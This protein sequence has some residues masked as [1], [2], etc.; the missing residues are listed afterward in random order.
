MQAA[1]T[2]KEAVTQSVGDGQG[3]RQQRGRIRHGGDQGR[4]AGLRPSPW[5]SGRR[6]RRVSAGR[7]RTRRPCRRPPARCPTS[8]RSCPRAAGPAR[9][10]GRHPP[11]AGRAR[12]GIVVVDLDPEPAAKHVHLEAR[13]AASMRHRVGDQLADEHLDVADELTICVREEIS[14][15]LARGARRLW[16]GR[17]V[18][19]VAAT[20]LRQGGGDEDLVDEA[21]RARRPS[22][23]SRPHRGSAPR[24]ADGVGAGSTAPRSPRPAQRS[25][26][27]GRASSPERPGIAR[28]SRIRCGGLR[29]S[30]AQ[31]LL[32]VVGLA[33]R[34][35][36]PRRGEQP[37]DEHALVRIVVDEEDRAAAPGRSRRH[38]AA[39]RVNRNVEPCPGD[40]CDADA[41]RPAPRR[42]TWR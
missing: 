6:R 27:S 30:A 28:S 42:V 9:R 2:V 16:R 23:R 20:A 36:R 24:R 7:S 1:A 13:F 29:R 10:D 19:H 17:E 35:W 26:R 41:C 4:D 3:D 11:R 18:E 14:H 38:G 34:R 40:D 21:A 12:R 22:R 32:R 25:W 31:R 39:G 15:E 8:S 37:G 33:R 5:G